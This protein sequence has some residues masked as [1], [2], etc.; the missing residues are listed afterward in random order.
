MALN[1]RV[2]SNPTRGT[3]QKIKMFEFRLNQTQSKALQK[4]LNNKELNELERIIVQHL[5]A[6]LDQALYYWK[7]FPGEF[8]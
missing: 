5:S 3:K 4:F 6:D 1:G 2:G 7:S 8:D